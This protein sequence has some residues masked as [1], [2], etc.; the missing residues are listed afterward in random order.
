MIALVLTCM[1]TLKVN[2]LIFLAT[3]YLHNI[4]QKGLLMLENFFGLF[5]CLL[6]FAFATQSN[7]V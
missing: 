3:Q 5:A 1:A 7:I 6:M 4:G 2:T